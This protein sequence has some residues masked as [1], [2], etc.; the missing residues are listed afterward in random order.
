MQFIEVINTL[1]EI[2]NEHIIYSNLPLTIDVA[3]FTA[4]TYA[5]LLKDNKGRTIQT[6]RLIVD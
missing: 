3:V 5:I 4:G 2:V 6:K 1:G